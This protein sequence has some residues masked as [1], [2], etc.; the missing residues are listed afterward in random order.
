MTPTRNPQSPVPQILPAL[1]A[2]LEDFAALADPV[3]LVAPSAPFAQLVESPFMRVSGN[4]VA[5]VSA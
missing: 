2:A 4:T 1:P 5:F 3:A